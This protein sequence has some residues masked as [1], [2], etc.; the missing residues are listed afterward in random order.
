MPDGPAPR[1]GARRRRT[2]PSSPRIGARIEAHFGAPQDIEWAARTARS[3][4]RPGPADHALPEPAAPTAD[5]LD[6]ARPDGDLRRGPASSSSCPTRSRRCSP[7]WSTVGHAV[8]A[9]ADR[10]VPRRRARS[11]PTDVGLPTINGYAYYR[12]SRAGHGRADADHGRVRLLAGCWP[13]GRWPGPLA[14]RLA[15]AVPR[16]GRRLDGAP[17]RRAVHVALMAG[18]T[19]LLDAGTEYYTAVQTI[20]PLG[21]VQRDRLHDASTG[22]SCAA[23]A[24]RRPRP[25]CSGSTARRSGPRSRSTRLAGWTRGHADLTAAL[26]AAPPERTAERLDGEPRTRWTR[27]SGPPSPAASG[28][29]SQCTATPSTPWTSPRR[30]LPT[31]PPRWSARC[32]STSMAGDGPGAAPG[33]RGGAVARRRRPASARGSTPRG[34]PCSPACSGGRKRRRP[35]ARTRSPTSGSPG[36]SCAGCC[37]SSVAAWSRAAS[38]SGPDD[39]FWLRRA[40]LHRVTAGPPSPGLVAERRALWRGQRRA[41]PPQVLPSG[42]CGRRR[43]GAGC[44]RR[45]REQTGDTIRGVGASA[46]QVTATARVLAG[47][48]DFGRLQPG[49]VLVASITTPAWTSLFARAAGGRHRHR[50]RR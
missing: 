20:I 2:R 12:Y 41:T 45:R 48:A 44:R 26:L 31:T 30:S 39:V 25:S 1:A 21:G 27:P 33:R 32:G 22:A 36:R 46:G 49:E 18:V 6:G 7:T 3:L 23:R 43:S 17:R 10:R 4:H 34:A 35:C 19:E 9:G 8:A 14:R 40:E 37:A 24:T 5:G 28:S 50:R 16:G 15:P 13:G 38:W 29:T 11:R 42:A 47:P